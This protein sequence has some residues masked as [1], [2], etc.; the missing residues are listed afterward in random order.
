MIIYCH[1]PGRLG[2]LLILQAHLFCFKKKYGVNYLFLPFY[3][4]LMYFKGTSRFVSK[5]KIIKY[6]QIPVYSIIYY[7]IYYITRILHKLKIKNKIINV[8]YIDWNEYINMESNFFIQ[9]A[10]FTSILILQGWKFRVPEKT[11]TEYIPDI[12]N[13]F[14]IKEQYKK[15]NFS[16]HEIKK[17]Y[18][19]IGIHIRRG[20]YIKFEGGRYYY[21]IEFYIKFINNLI[22]LFPNNK[23]FFYICS[24][25]KLNAS[26]FKNQLNNPFYISNHSFIQ[27]LYILSEC[28]YIAAPPSTFSLWAAFMGNVPIY[29]ISSDQS[30]PINIHEFKIINY[31]T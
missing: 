16:L 1:K 18:I 31:L 4:Y 21:S 3:N 2:N 12:R 23:V 7:L 19:L 26:Y 6:V 9:E 22:K 10:R 29:E 20:D 27:D 28:N 30:Y 13:Y 17:E 25:E 15:I 11:F 24:D 5:Y 8:L 14:S